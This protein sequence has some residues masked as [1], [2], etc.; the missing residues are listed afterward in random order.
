MQDQKRPPKDFILKTIVGHETA[1]ST[2]LEENNT[3]ATYIITVL[4]QIWKESEGE[5]SKI[6][7]QPISFI[8]KARRYIK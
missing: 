8:R 4:T 7:K 3:L 5:I 1:F 6:V 2:F